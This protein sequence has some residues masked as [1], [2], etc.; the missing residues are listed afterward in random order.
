MDVRG[1]WEE[2]RRLHKS[3]SGQKGKTEHGPCSLPEKTAARNTGTHGL[4]VPSSL[5]RL[6]REKLQGGIIKEDML[7]GGALESMAAAPTQHPLP[8]E[9][10]ILSSLV[11][12][13]PPALL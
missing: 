6:W 13:L 5:V 1:R 7:R 12:S 9:G 3:C 8:G 2:Q 11:S 4:V 10:V